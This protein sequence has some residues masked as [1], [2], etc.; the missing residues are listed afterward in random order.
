MG[1]VAQSGQ[2][3]LVADTTQDPRYLLD[4]E[5]RYS[6]LAVP[7]VA[8]NRVIGVIDL[9]HP[10]KSFFT[11]HHREALQTIAAICSS[12]IAQAW[13]EE[14][15]RKARL[16]QVEADYIKRMDR[17]KSQ[18]FANVS[19]EFR[20]PLHLILAPLR[21][22]DKAI[23]QSEKDMMARNAQRLLRLVNQL[24]DLAK[25]E[26]GMLR[27][28][29]ETGD[30]VEFLRDTAQPFRTLAESKGIRY[31]IELPGESRVVPFDRDKLEKIVSN[32]LSNAIKFT[33][34]GGSV[35]IQAK[36]AP[37]IGLRIVVSDTG[38][39]IPEALQARIFGRFYQIDA[40]PTRDFE[41][42]GLGLALTK[43]LVELCGGTIRVMSEA[44]AGSTF[45]VELPLPA[46]AT[47]HPV[48]PGAAWAE[49]PP[50]NGTRSIEEDA[51][52][53]AG[54]DAEAAETEPDGKPTILLVEDH[55]E[56]REYLRQQLADRYRVV[57]AT[58]GEEGLQ[59]ACATVPDV[60]ISD[61]MMPVMDGMTLTRRLKADERTSHIPV[62]LLT[63]KDDVGSRTEGFEGGAEQYL[64]KP[65]ATEELL[66]RLQSLLTQRSR[67][68]KK[69][70][71][72]VLLQ[73][74]AT[75][76]RDRE[77]EFLEKLIAVVD[78]HLADET[79]G[80]EVLQQ[81]IGMSR[82]QLHRKLKALTDQSASDFI[83]TIRLQRAADLLR[84][85]GTP[86]AE[87]AYASGFSHL[88][89]FSKCFKEQF[90]VLPS[91]FAKGRR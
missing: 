74:S 39:G 32:L 20:T 83:R 70:S 44:G 59:V 41:G 33:P 2:P 75:P 69:Y 24:L 35:T 88:S 86:V 73:P 78:E 8:Q 67:L 57:G 46:D 71:R 13:A 30:V 68:Q 19:H 84:Q 37:S 50:L 31:R 51:E 80:V 36:M 90:G 6:E 55:A 43:E 49:K 15:A 34:L 28:W 91:E 29:L 42:S 61:V 81:E 17:V 40:S 1:S 12:K 60:V 27:L 11:D 63:A 21:K 3:E 82:M 52:S 10:E 72:E 62:I 85:P 7:L 45:T 4:D 5:Q 79:F 76:V 66:A 16:A 53:A 26:M 22:R 48:E 47:A 58:Q 18:F 54:T 77:A 9:E 56:L 87:A 64:A 65:F 38:R 89:Y 23:S 25:A 14:E